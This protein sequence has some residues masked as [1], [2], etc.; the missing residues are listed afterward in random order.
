MNDDLINYCDQAHAEISIDE[1][2]TLG[3]KDN[4]DNGHQDA[5]LL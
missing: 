2:Q 1:P 5:T 4:G 3:Q